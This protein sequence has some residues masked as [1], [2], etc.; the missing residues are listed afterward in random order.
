MEFFRQWS[1]QTNRSNNYRFAGES[2]SL[3]VI[4]LNQDPFDQLTAGYPYMFHKYLSISSPDRSLRLD[5]DEA[6]GEIF[7]WVDDL[8]GE[9]NRA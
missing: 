1:F 8:C 4:S 5:F 2:H 6:S 9:L 3:I 7:I